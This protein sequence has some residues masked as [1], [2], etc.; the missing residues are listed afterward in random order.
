MCIF[1]T[2][3]DPMQSLVR[4]VQDLP[5]QYRRTNRE[6]PSCESP[7]MASMVKQ[8]IELNSVMDDI[9]Y[10]FNRETSDLDY[11]TYDKVLLL[12]DELVLQTS[13][14]YAYIQQYYYLLIQ[15]TC[16]FLAV[17]LRL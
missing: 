11:Q 3:Q 8:L 9:R 13:K 4:Q 7:Y 15:L 16:N 17:K 14:M 5:R 12:F 10:I 2:F 1:D 6:W